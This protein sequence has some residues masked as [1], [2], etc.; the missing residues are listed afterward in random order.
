[1]EVGPTSHLA[2]EAHLALVVG[3][4]GSGKSTFLDQLSLHKSYAVLEPTST[5]EA[6]QFKTDNVSTLVNV[7][8][9]D[10]RER[11]YTILNDTH[12]LLISQRLNDGGRVATSGNHIVTALSHALMRQIT[13]PS[14]TDSS[15]EKV[16][17]DWLNSPCT[18]PDIFVL[19]HAP[20]GTILDRIIARQV[21]GDADEKFWGFNAP[22]FLDRYQ[23]AWHTVLDL[24]KS[25]SQIACLDFDSSKMR[26]TEMIEEYDHLV[27]TE[28]YE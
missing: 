26:P 10:E 1:M 13:E 27:L 16:T 18:K 6:R 28:Q 11:L 4:D 17:Y 24:L 20:F 9:V 25:D 5:P 22:Y 7:P 14:I 2:K 3:I 12:D 21:E 8:L 15:P 19:V 23:D